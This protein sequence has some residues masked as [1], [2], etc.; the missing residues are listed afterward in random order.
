M[1]KEEEWKMKRE[2]RRRRKRNGGAMD[3]EEVRECM[4]IKMSSLCIL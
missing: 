1:R 3:E 2:W 4:N